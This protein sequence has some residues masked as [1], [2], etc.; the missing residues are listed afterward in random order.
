MHEQEHTMSFASFLHH[1]PNLIH[2]SYK[3]SKLSTIL[4]TI[5]KCQINEGSPF[6]NN[7]LYYLNYYL[8][9]LFNSPKSHP[10]SYRVELLLKR[11][12]RFASYLTNLDNFELWSCFIFYFIFLNIRLGITLMGVHSGVASSNIYS[13]RPIL[14]A[15]YDYVCLFWTLVVFNA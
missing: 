4:S 11:G 3:L 5:Y 10:A 12:H 2:H 9:L 13:L 1:L 15:P 6:I 8:P 7:T 14:F